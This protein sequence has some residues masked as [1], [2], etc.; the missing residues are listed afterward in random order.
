METIVSIILK[1]IHNCRSYGPDKLERINGHTDNTPN[2]HYDTYVSLTT[3]GL[4]KKLHKQ[5]NP[6]PIKLSFLHVCDTSLMKTQLEKEKLLLTSNLSFSQ[7]VLIVWR[8]LC[9]FH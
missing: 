2:C 9:Y 5:F 7:C 4:D 3:S 6:F 8:I 1:P